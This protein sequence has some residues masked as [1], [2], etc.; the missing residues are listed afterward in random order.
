MRI[1]LPDGRCRTLSPDAWLASNRRG[2]DAL[3]R[4]IRNADGDT[5]TPRGLD[6]SGVMLPPD[7][8][9][10]ERLDREMEQRGGLLRA[11][12]SLIAGGQGRDAESIV[13]AACS[14]GIVVCA[15]VLGGVIGL[16]LWAMGGGA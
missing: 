2:T 7:I 11:D 6:D 12:Q 1:Y 16:V 15:A 13:S 14:V 5:Y 8:S 4:A 9:E 10:A 3:S